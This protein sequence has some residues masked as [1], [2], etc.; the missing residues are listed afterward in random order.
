MN[1][2]IRNAHVVA[3][4]TSFAALAT[5]AGGAM[6]QEAVARPL[7]PIS[8]KTR[9][10]VHA[11]LLQARADGTL[12]VTEFHAPQAFVAQKSRAQVRSELL[13]AIASGELDT[14]NDESKE[15]V[16]TRATPRHAGPTTIA[17]VAR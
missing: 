16:T 2:F 10:A 17:A 12:Q 9:A 11:E 3:L 6:A 8:D 7:P 15:L 14:R 4:V 1:T 13:E 5:F